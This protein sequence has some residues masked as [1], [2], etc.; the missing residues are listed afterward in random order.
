MNAT[1]ETLKES[2]RSIEE[3]IKR[4][5]GPHIY[6]LSWTYGPGEKEMKLAKD[7]MRKRKEYLDK[8][9]AL[10][11]TPAEVER[12]ARINNL[13][14]EATDRTYAAS[15][16]LYRA[17]LRLEPDKAFDDDYEVKSE[18]LLS[19]WGEEEAMVEQE[20]DANYP[21][22]FPYMLELLSR[23]KEMG[24][25]CGENIIGSSISFQTDS[26]NPEVS[27][28]ELGCVNCYDDEL[29][30]AEE[31]LMCSKLKDIKV[32]YAVHDICCHKH[33]SIADLLRMRWY[34][35]CDQL[36]C[37]H[38]IHT[39]PLHEEEV[40]DDDS[41]KLYLSANFRPTD[42]DLDLLDIESVEF[43]DEI[44]E[45]QDTDR[46]RRVLIVVENEIKR[47][48]KDD[49]L[50]FC[51]HLAYEEDRERV[52]SLIMTRSL[53]L[54]CMFHLHATSAEVGRF[55]HV[56]RI[57]YDAEHQLSHRS[58]NL[59]RQMLR[60]D[61][62]PEL[63]QADRW[64]VDGSLRAVCCDRNS[65]LQLPEDEFY[66]SDFAYM[67][68]LQYEIEE[69]SSQTILGNFSYYEPWM[70][71][72][73]TDEQLGFDTALSDEILD[74][75]GGHLYTPQLE[76]INV[77]YAIHGLCTHQSYSIPDML[78]L[79]EYWAECRMERQKDFFFLP[80]YNVSCC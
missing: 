2:I 7:M 58:A 26:H 13:L 24:L 22:D 5:I 62:L 50:F 51:H 65:V 8:L 30:W 34:E 76:H 10:Q 31:G 41:E 59:L 27:D 77:C 12:F 53:I 54:N 67:I 43:I 37:Q 14:R 75:K 47:I 25:S 72:E 60:S 33:Y 17:L 73:M 28:E 4:Y 78:R 23:I 1:I 38:F 63:N 6:R 39:V 49:P 35:Q 48:V 56:N 52:H 18:L 32:C 55:E 68:R 36:I 19:C 69:Y 21:S 15:G 46:L 80:E 3:R 61:Y 44:K 11:A 70:E 71:P 29:T 79:N 64:L 42:I 45:S 9:F 40:R 66:G 57:L 20:E 16:N 74:W